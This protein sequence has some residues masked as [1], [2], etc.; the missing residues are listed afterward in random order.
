MYAN[1]YVGFNTF[2]HTQT[3]PIRIDGPDGNPQGWNR[4]RQN[5]VLNDSGWAATGGTRTTGARPAPRSDSPALQPTRPARVAARWRL[6]RGQRVEQ[7]A[8]H[9]ARCRRSQDGALHRDGPAG[10]Q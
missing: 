8:R 1:V 4:L 5:I 7:R 3:W 6:C 9:L 10:P 2:A